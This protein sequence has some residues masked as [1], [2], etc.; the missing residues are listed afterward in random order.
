MIIMRYENTIVYFSFL[1]N[2]DIEYRTSS[3]DK[4][5]IDIGVLR[6]FATGQRVFQE[7]YLSGF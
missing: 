4:N 5:H 6:Y 2:C 7:N 3:V 1:Q